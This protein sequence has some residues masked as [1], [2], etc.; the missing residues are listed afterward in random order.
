MDLQNV[1]LD[2]CGKQAIT[3]ANTANLLIC[4]GIKNEA[5]VNPIRTGGGG[6]FGG[7]TKI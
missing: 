5:N 4:K 7:P 6:G 2:F 3:F 1:C